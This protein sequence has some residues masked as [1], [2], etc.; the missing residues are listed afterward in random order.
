VTDIVERLL[1]LWDTRPP[2]TMAVLLVVVLVVV[3]A[4]IATIVGDWSV[5]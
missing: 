1:S 3:L 2:H 4:V 5:Q